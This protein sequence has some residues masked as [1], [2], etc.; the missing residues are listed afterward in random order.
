LLIK[1]TGLFLSLIISTSA[2]GR[3]EVKLSEID[4]LAGAI[5]LEAR[6]ESLKGQLA[7]AGV[8]KNRKVTKIKPI[9]KVLTEPKQFS[10]FSIKAVRVMKAQNSDSWQDAVQMA[11]LAMSTKTDPSKGSTFFQLRKIP[12]QSKKYVV[13]AHIGNHKFMREKHPSWQ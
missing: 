12:H 5:Y 2:F 10:N 3:T 11:K 9:C 6:G 1:L 7:V 8:I 13:V 4:C